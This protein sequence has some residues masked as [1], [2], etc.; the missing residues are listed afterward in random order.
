MKSNN[1]DLLKVLLWI[2]ALCVAGCSP[3]GTPKTPTPAVMTVISPVDVTPTL[4]PFTGKIAFV[5]GTGNIYDNAIYVMNADGSGLKNLTPNR[6]FNGEPA[7]SPDGKYIAFTSIAYTSLKDGDTQIFIMKADG[8]DQKQLTF[9]T[10]GSYQPAWS[11]DGKYITFVSQREN[12][13]SDRGTPL[14]MGF[15]M[16]SDGTEQRQL[17]N[18]QD[19]VDGI[20]WYPTGGLI[21]V[22]VAADRYTVKTYLVDLDGVIQKQLSEFVTPG[23]PSWSPFNGEVVVFDSTVGRSDCSG[24]IVMKANGS[25]QKCLIIDHI[26]PPADNGG[27]S[28]SPDGKYIIFSSNHDNNQNIYLVKPDG[29]DLTQLTN[30]TGMNISPVWSAAP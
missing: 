11:P 1:P 16:K 26:L 9:G 30:M 18:N 12:V 27:S 6:P 25:D 20:S 2:G 17:T 10:P 21:S 13:L 5:H 4:L 24:I 19:F 22:S 8:S 15:I 23:I 7:W 28:W 14:Q 3:T 29:S